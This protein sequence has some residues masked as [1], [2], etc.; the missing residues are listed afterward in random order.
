MRFLKQ[1]LFLVILVGIV[2]AG[3]VVAIVVVSS[4][5][6]KIDDQLAEREKLSGDL[7][8][9]AR[10]DRANPAVNQAE[11]RRVESVTSAYRG[12]VVYSIGENRRN[13]P[14]LKVQLDKLRPAF[15]IDRDLYRQYGG[16]LT[17]EEGYGREVRKFL[18]MLEPTVEPSADEI[19]AEIDAATARLTR[20]AED[21]EEAPV[22]EEP[23]RRRGVGSEITQQAQQEGTLAARVKKAREGRIYATP[24]AL[25][26]YVQFP[27]GSST[28][29]QLWEM[30]LNLWIQGD[31]IRAIKKTN[32]QVFGD[33]EDN[34]IS[35]AVKR[36]VAIDV[37]EKYVGVG[38]TTRRE[39]DMDPEMGS[40]SAWKEAPAGPA[41]AASLT[42]EITNKNFDVVHYAFTVVMPPRHL[43]TLM[44]NLMGNAYHKALRI[45]M[46]PPEPGEFYYGTD[47]VMEV[48]IYGEQLLLTAWTRG[49]WLEEKPGAGKW[50]EECPPLVPREILEAADFPTEALRPE[51]E[52]RKRSAASGR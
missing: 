9:L 21:K 2:L 52:D 34:V 25:D 39:G 10:G 26:T 37:T 40:F 50:S 15:P 4:I 23:V 45:D 17:V 18:T 46:N 36:L 47:P 7:R 1:N 3:M 35:A 27:T 38:E 33:R 49:T 31:I 41:R 32:E 16:R 44:R 48:T 6:G 28:N 5:S 22:L 14:V 51:D 30:Q 42:G 19:K 43:D 13:Y 11:K 8:K 29:A 12:A 20:E 24:K